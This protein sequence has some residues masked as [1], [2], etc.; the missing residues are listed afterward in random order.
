MYKYSKLTRVFIAL[1]ITI[2]LQVL[3]IVLLGLAQSGSQQG[4]ERAMILLGGDFTNGGYIQFLTFVAFFWGLIEVQYFLFW[5][6][7]ERKYLSVELLPGEEHAILGEVE[8]NKIRLQVSD[9]LRKKKQESALG[10]YFLLEI[11]KKACTKF[12]SDNS[13]ESA[14]MIV[15]SQSR[16]NREKTESSQSGIRYLLWAIPS[17]GFVGTILGIS[18]SLSIAGSGDIDRITAALGVAF[19]T[20]LLALVLSLILMYLYHGLQEKSELLHYDIEE[21]VV[22]NLINKIDVN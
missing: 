12:R 16:I 20:T 8:V 13:S 7:F 4:L 19:D 3:F 21:F 6:S 14:F 5:T 17:I 10:S 22:E 15:E 11:I 18:Q 1:G 2:L 9:Y